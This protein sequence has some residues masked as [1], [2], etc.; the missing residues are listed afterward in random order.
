MSRSDAS[1]D[2]DRHE[3]A[4]LALPWLLAGTLE[5][6]ELAMV[7][8]HV[9]GCEHCQADLA[10][11]RNLRAAGCGAA[12]AIDPG[13]ALQKLLPRLPPKHGTITRAGGKKAAAND[14]NWLRVVAAGQLAVIAVL[15][16]LLLAPRDEAS[17]RAPGTPEQ[18]LRRILRQSGARVVDGPTV[19]DAWVLA[20]PPAHTGAALRR[21][22]G[23]ASVTLAQPLATEG[24][25]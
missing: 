22:R 19:A 23:E 1:F 13:Q 6:D 25:P 4:Q 14:S 20:V 3:A 17:Y 24:K 7:E 11:E 21:L 12:P 16:A 15:A 18:E 9:R 2:K 5:G 8:E 10:W